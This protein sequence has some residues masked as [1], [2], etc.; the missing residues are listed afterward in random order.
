[1]PA[2]TDDVPKVD[3]R[4]L[5]I[6][7]RLPITVKRS[8]DGKYDYS[9]SSGGL[10]TGLSGLAKTTTFLWYG[11]PGL[12]IPK[13]EVPDVTS[14]LKEQDERFDAVPVFMSDELADRHYN[15]FSSTHTLTSS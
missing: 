15:G 13:D 8:T 12:E 2:S 3:S 14:K 7:N 10:V 6:S 9:L 1:M 4:L 11:W 5:L